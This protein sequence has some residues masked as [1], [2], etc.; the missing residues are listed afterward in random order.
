MDK[1]DI[2]L[3]FDSI[4]GVNLS[5]R[6]SSVFYFYVDETPEDGDGKRGAG[7]G[8]TGNTFDEGLWVGEGDSALDTAKHLKRNLVNAVD[9]AERHGYGRE[10]YIDLNAVIQKSL[11][12]T[13]KMLHGG[14]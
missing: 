5:V 10:Q 8:I 7:V 2:W 12:G 3:E 11:E 4:D 1:D 6:S 13:Y 9:Y 14:A